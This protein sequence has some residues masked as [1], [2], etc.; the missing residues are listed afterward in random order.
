MRAATRAGGEI[1][2]LGRRSARPRFPSLVAICDISGSMA[3]YSRTLL[4]FLHAVANCKGAEWS[5]LHAFTFGTRLTN[6]TRHLRQS[7]PDAALSAAG[8]EAKDWEGG[9]RI[10]DCLRAYNRDWHRRIAGQGAIVLLISDGLESGDPEILA[11]EADRLRRSSRRF[12]WINPLLR[13]EGFAPKA[14]GVRALLPHV[15]CFRSAHNIASLADLAEAVSNSGD[16]GEKR[17]L[18]ER[19]G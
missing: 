6:I 12:V 5:S 15:D 13:W 17:R 1:R 7:D 8:S 11:D 18:L 3:A 10:G 19:L 9:T 16:E 14:A 2:N 4:Q